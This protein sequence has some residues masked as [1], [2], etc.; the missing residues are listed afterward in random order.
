MDGV[1]AIFHFYCKAHHYAAKY[2]HVQ[3]LAARQMPRKWS[4]R[5]VIEE[6]CWFFLNTI[7]CWGILF[8]CVKE[9]PQPKGLW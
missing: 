3:Q 9:R 7:G 8:V 6:N 4:H 2:V 5:E 1:L